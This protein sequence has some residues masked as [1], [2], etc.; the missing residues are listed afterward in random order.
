MEYEVVYGSELS[1]LEYE[2]KRNLAQDWEP[3]GGVAIA[4]SEGGGYFWAQAMVKRKPRRWFG[5]F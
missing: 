2:V 3:I 1:D 4:P 5:R